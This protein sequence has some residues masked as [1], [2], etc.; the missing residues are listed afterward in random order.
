MSDRWKTYLKEVRAVGMIRQ[1]RTAEVIVGDFK[2]PQAM[3]MDDD[4]ELA[5]DNEGWHVEVT[6]HAE[7][8]YEWLVVQMQED[9]RGI[10]RLWCDNY[11]AGCVDETLDRFL[12]EH[13][14]DEQSTES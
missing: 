12:K 13:F 4:L 9:V 3:P 11:P 7:G 1:A 2:L 6:I 8:N 14:P 5:W 10:S